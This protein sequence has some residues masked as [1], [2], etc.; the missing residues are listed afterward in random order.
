MTSRNRKKRKEKRKKRFSKKIRSEKKGE[1]KKNVTVRRGEEEKKHEDA[2]TAP[3]MRCQ[4]ALK[5][6][7]V[8]LMAWR[9]HRIKQIPK[10]PKQL[11]TMIQHLMLQ[12]HEKKNKMKIK[13]SIRKKHQ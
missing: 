8:C 4:Q 3:Q 5:S 6:S 7:R 2:V 12:G 9:E 10:A 11:E 1:E 13:M